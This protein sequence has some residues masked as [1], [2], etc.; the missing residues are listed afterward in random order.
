MKKYYEVEIEKHHS[1]FGMY[2]A[3]ELSEGVASLPDIIE[4]ISQ[5]LKAEIFELGK[6]TLP[7]GIEDIRGRI[8]NEPEMIFGLMENIEGEEKPRYFGIN[9]K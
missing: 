4:E 6:D 5:N 2:Q 7:V 3:G 8:Y 9:Y 1:G